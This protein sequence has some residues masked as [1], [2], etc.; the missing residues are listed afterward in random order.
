MDDFPPRPTPAQA[1]ELIRRQRGR[2][3]ALMVVLVCL[4]ILFFGI[5]VV[6]LG[7]MG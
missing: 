5:T 3:I 4:V 2:N 1:A 6:K 7:H